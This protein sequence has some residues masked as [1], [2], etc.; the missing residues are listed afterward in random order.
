MSKLFTLQITASKCS[1]MI[2]VNDIITYIETEGYNIDFELPI[3]H[4]TSFGG[5]I[6]SIKL[7]P[8]KNEKT[9][10]KIA[11]LKVIVFERD[12]REERESRLNIA[13][14][15]APD[16]SANETPPP[17]TVIN[18]ISFE[19]NDTFFNNNAWASNLEP[20]IK[21]NIYTQ[22]ITFYKQFHSLM[23]SKNL[24][25][26]MS[27]LQERMLHYSKT[28]FLDKNEFTEQNYEFYDSMF[29]N[30][31]IIPW[32]LQKQKLILI[33]NFGSKLFTLKNEI[34]ESPLIFYDKKEK[35]SH[36]VDFFIGKTK[37]EKE[38]KIIL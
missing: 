24:K 11:R 20:L 5:N 18:D 38:F 26:I 9:I 25:L 1:Y 19:N 37:D 28:N 4:L 17:Y 10:S 6:V 22:V 23:A 36:Y 34:Q 30:E 15:S 14:F 32:P 8:L 35:E 29:A 27:L 13:Q 33:D 16:F 2:R 7:L 3:N 31:N 21:D 12:Y